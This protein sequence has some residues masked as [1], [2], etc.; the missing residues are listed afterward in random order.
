[1][2][3]VRARGDINMGREDRVVRGCVSFTL[4]LLAGFA[5]IASGG[6]GVSSAVFVLIGLYFA[7]TGAAG[8]DPFYRRFGIDTHGREDAQ[9]GPGALTV[10]DLRQEQ[11]AAARDQLD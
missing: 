3:M 5:V 6:V 2:R 8:R 11:P 9:S 7:L 1:M 10:L 4:L